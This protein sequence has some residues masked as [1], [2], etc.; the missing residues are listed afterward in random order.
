M[1]VIARLYGIDRPEEYTIG[2]FVGDE[3]RGMGEA[4]AS[5]LMTIAVNGEKGEKVSFRLYHKPTGTL[6]NVRES[7]ISFSGH[8]GSHCTPVVLHPEVTGIHPV[9][10]D[11]SAGHRECYDLQGRR[12]TSADRTSAGNK[13][14][15]IITVTEGGHRV[16]RKI[17]SK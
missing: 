3:C 14:L 9:V 7:G 1:P 16:T 2:A 5:G 15:Y 4:T 10:A 17:I 8:A 13:G 6:T 12:I 11:L